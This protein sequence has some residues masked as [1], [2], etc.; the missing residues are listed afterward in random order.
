MRRIMMVAGILFST[1]FAEAASPQP[2]QL[3]LTLDLQPAVSLPGVP[4]SF[5]V[6]FTNASG[7]P[8]MIPTKA[9]LLVRDDQG[10]T[11]LAACDVTHKVHNVDEWAG[12]TILPRQAA[13][14]TLSTEGLM[15]HPAW[16]LDSRLS[17][18][19]RFELQLFVSDNLREGLGIE[20]IRQRAA[21]S[22]TAILT[23][24]EPT[25][26]DAEVWRLMKTS[27]R[28][29]SPGLVFGP[30]G[31]ELAKRVIAEHSNSSY[32]A[33]FASTCAAPTTEERESILRQWL[34]RAPGDSLTNWRKLRLA[35]YEIG[36][37][38]EYGHQHPELSHTSETNARAI[39]NT[40]L[41]ESNDDDLKKRAKE[42]LDYL[43]D[44][45]I[46]W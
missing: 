20:E 11:F 1:T 8:V 10:Q 45:P 26:V 34:S 25:G 36:L 18:P 40:L 7:L 17:R 30:A 29:W 33:W 27:D 12:Q 24:Q 2:T 13:A 23:V 28:N 42:R 9:T 16:F 38:G 14:Y 46:E 15:D 3:S 39:L 21:V 22:N 4:V 19:G 43:D 44:P 35:Q 6:T 32:A 37:A 41:K 5:R 31:Q